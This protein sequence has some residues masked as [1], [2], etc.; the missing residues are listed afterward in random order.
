MRRGRARSQGLGA[1]A[2]DAA[3]LYTAF[4]VPEQSPEMAARIAGWYGV[5]ESA[6]DG[7]G[8]KHH[9]DAVIC[10]SSGTVVRARLYHLAPA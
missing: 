6:I 2:A 5:L 3:T 4:I 9:Y 8:R 10:P 7:H 1:L